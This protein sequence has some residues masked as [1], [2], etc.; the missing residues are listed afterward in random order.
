MRSRLLVLGLAAA[1]LMGLRVNADSG[2]SA[3]TAPAPA[4]ASCGAP[5]AEETCTVCAARPCDLFK[6]LM[7]LAACRTCAAPEIPAPACA[8]CA[9]AIPECT[10]CAPALP[11]L[12]ALPAAPCATCAPAIPE[13]T[14]CAAPIPE[15]ACPTCGKTECTACEGAAVCP[16]GPVASLGA[17]A[18]GPATVLCGSVRGVRC[19]VS[20]LF[21]ALAEA[22]A[23][24]TICS[25]C[26]PCG[27]PGCPTCG[28][29]VIPETTCSACAAA[30]AADPAP[31]DA[32]PAA[33][34][35]PENLPESPTFTE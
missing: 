4:C 16:P 27:A 23:P 6:G 30:A 35:T 17:A 7:S 12:P 33:A 2:T 14:S 22:A 19:L 28:G 32:V 20:G 18:C 8:T 15:P 24:R 34:P 9:P 29:A 1:A 31:S 11:A 5:V 21:G 26:S 25:S 13:C 10:T 3:D